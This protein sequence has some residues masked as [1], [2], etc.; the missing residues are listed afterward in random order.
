MVQLVKVVKS[1]LARYQ[2]KV[3]RAKRCAHV[4]KVQVTTLVIRSN[5][6]F[7][8]RL[9]LCPFYYG[10]EFSH[11]LG[12]IDNGL[13]GGH[14]PSMELLYLFVNFHFKLY[15]LSFTYLIIVFNGNAVYFGAYICQLGLESMSPTH[16]LYNKAT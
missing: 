6:F 15:E 2:S 5:F 3:T 7:N 10:S 13:K 8:G 4:N 1:Y 14:T 16:S 9:I 11:S 12:V